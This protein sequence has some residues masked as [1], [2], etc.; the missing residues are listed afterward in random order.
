MTDHSA[1]G[2]GERFVRE[3]RENVE[4]LVGLYDPEEEHD[5]CGVGLV[6]AIDGKPRRQVVEAA[7][8]ALKRIWHRGAVDADGKTGDGAG[9]H[10]EIPLA[11]FRDY[12]DDRHSPQRPTPRVGHPRPACRRSGVPAADRPRW[13]GALPHHRGDRDPRQAAMPSMAGAR[14]R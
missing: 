5:A 6:A 2:S 4:R 1:P 10:V 8:G 9:I 11:F 7:I 3:Y 14:S 13:A 12:I